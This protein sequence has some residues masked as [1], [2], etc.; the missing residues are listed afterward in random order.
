LVANKTDLKQRRVI[1]MK[2]GKELAESHGLEYRNFYATFVYKIL[3]CLI[4]LILSQVF[5]LFRNKIKTLKQHFTILQAHIIKCIM[6]GLVRCSQWCENG[7]RRIL[8]SLFML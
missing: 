2:Q 8:N 3:A 1:S 5:V 7:L 4:L 6:T